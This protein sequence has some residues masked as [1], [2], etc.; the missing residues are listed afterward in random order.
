[1]RLL[2]ITLMHVRNR[3][4]RHLSDV[5]CKTS[6]I[7]LAKASSRCLTKMSFRFAFKTSFGY[8]DH[9]L[10]RC[11]ACLDKISLR[12]LIDVFLPTGVFQKR[13]EIPG[14]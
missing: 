7:Y 6:T 5:F 9:V 3:L 2:Q 12:Y 13:C 14:F 4:I 10:A 8:L 11:L 1:M